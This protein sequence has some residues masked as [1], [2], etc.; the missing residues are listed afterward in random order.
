M[1]KIFVMVTLCVISI[2]ACSQTYYKIHSNATG[3]W[4][5]N[6]QTYQW[7]SRWY[8]D[9]NL[10]M[11]GKIILV[12]DN[13]GSA[14]I[15]GNQVLNQDLAEYQQ[16]MWEAVDERQRTCH[17]KLLYPKSNG[18]LTGA[19]QMYILYDNY[20]FVYDVSNE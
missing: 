14:Y 15:T 16:F 4:N 11:K 17:V 9:M 5:N 6:T 7:G 10:T 12:S 20:A 18:Q 19:C 8:I 2:V 1:K 13:A 3:V